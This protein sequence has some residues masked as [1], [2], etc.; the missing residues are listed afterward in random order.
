M[1]KVVFSYSHVDEDLRNELEKHLSPLQRLGKID[2]WHDRRINPGDVFD[3]EISQHFAD[4][5][6]VLLLISSDFIASNYCYEVEMKNALE[7]HERG[8]AVVIPIILR[9]C[10]WHSLPFGHILAATTDGKPIVKFSNIDD[11]FVEVVNAVSKAL[12]KVVPS[13]G[14]TVSASVSPA[15]MSVIGSST[16]IQTSSSQVP[17]SSNLAIKKEFTDR[18]RDVAIREG[19]NYVMCFFENSLAELVNRNPG[20][21]TDFHQRD[22]DSFE[23]AVY[24]NGDRATKCGIWKDGN[25]KAMGNIFYS[26]SGISHNSYNESMSI[27]DDGTVLG[28]NALMGMIHGEPRGTLL[29]EQGMA[30]YLWAQFINP[31]K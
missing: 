18:D 14:T 7:R 23:C 12:D 24:L 2:A 25:Q 28:F 21:D 11:G 16:A 17:R 19:F 26:S 22:P 27:A 1:T 13:P 5:G 4:A 31:L 20:I 10:A 15:V 30:E 3:A 29:T 6:I 8:E 9:P